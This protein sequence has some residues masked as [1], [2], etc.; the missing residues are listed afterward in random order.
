[1]TE[2]YFCHRR[3]GCP[4]PGRGEGETGRT[5]PLFRRRRDVII[6]A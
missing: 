4:G 1:M 6:V 2:E 5:F 3:D